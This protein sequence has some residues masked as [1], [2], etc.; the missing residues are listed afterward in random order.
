MECRLRARPNRPTSVPDLT[1]ASCGWMEANPRSN[2]STSREKSSQKCGGCKSSK[3]GTNSIINGHNFGMRCWISRC[4]HPFGH[5]VY[6]YIFQ[7]SPS[8]S[9]FCFMLTG[10][11]IYCLEYMTCH[12][13]HIIWWRMRRKKWR[14]TYDELMTRLLHRWIQTNCSRLYFN[15]CRFESVAGRV[16]HTCSQNLPT[17]IFQVAR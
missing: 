16:L 6:I 2:V 10:V 12:I 4:P 5:V 13:R 11:W 15:T 7:T 14:Q 8:M 9:I 17:R 3:W 1:N